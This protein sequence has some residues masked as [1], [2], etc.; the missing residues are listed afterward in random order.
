MVSAPTRF[1]YCPKP[2]HKLNSL[3][4]EHISEYHVAP[5]GKSH[6]ILPHIC[7]TANTN[8]LDTDV[9]ST[10]L[11][12]NDI[13]NS[14]YSA[15]SS[16]PNCNAGSTQLAGNNIFCSPSAVD[17]LGGSI[18]N[19]NMKDKLIPK[20]CN[21]QSNSVS[22]SVVQQDHNR[23]DDINYNDRRLET[24]TMAEKSSDQVLYI[25]AII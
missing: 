1:L 24:E 4:S 11:A 18:S 2:N 23:I 16:E 13:C 15:N 17:L 22:V 6:A 10:Q 7:D 25:S 3:P 9:G 19:V 20:S 21:S 14:S 5:T 12:V 8:V